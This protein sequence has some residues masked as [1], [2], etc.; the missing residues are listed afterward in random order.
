MS[1]TTPKSLT[2]T[3]GLDA[4]RKRVEDEIGLS[5]LYP[6]SLRIPIPF[7][8]TAFQ[9]L[10]PNIEK[11]GIKCQDTTT[12]IYKSN[13]LFDRYLSDYIA[14]QIRIDKIVVSEYELFHRAIQQ[15]HRFNQIRHYLTTAG[16]LGPMWLYHAIARPILTSYGYTIY[17]VSSNPRFQPIVTNH[18]PILRRIFTNAHDIL[19]KIVN[20]R[21]IEHYIHLFDNEAIELRG[22]G[23]R[24]EP[25][26][27]SEIFYNYILKQFVMSKPLNIPVLHNYI[28]RYEDISPRPSHTVITK[29][30]K[31]E[32]RRRGSLPTSLPTI[33]PPTSTTGRNTLKR[34]SPTTL[35]PSPILPTM[36]MNTPRH[37]QRKNTRRTRSPIANRPVQVAPGYR[38]PSPYYSPPTPP[39]SNSN[40]SAN[41]ANSFVTARGN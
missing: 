20:I 31:K 5:D 34:R 39:N 30:A 36:V 28:R 26:T 38:P 29:P 27:S 16:A 12:F 13:L 4:L 33:I 9:S 32:Y 2:E 15:T 8:V 35:I 6:R 25:E 10:I 23:F 18:Q 3:I 37:L 41:S 19:P 17:F 21:A 7:N 11:I 1:A 22:R 24:T 14:T 40:R